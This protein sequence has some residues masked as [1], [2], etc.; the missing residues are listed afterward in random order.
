MTE[1]LPPSDAPVSPGTGFRFDGGTVVW[2]QTT[3]ATT[4]QNGIFDDNDDWLATYSFS[5]QVVV[6]VGAGGGALVRRMKLAENNSPI[7]RDRIFGFYNYF[8]NVPGGFGDVHRFTPGFEKTFVDGI[9]SLDVRLPFAS[10]LSSNQ[11]AGVAES[12]GAE[13][14]NVTATWKAILIQRQ[15]VLVSGGVGLG[16]PTAD[17]TR[18][19]MP[20]GTPLLHIHNDAL[21]VLPFA[22]FLWTPDDENFVQGFLQFDLDTNGN[23]VYGGPTGSLPSLGRIQD[24]ALMYMDVT[25]GTWLHRNPGGCGITGIAPVIELH[26][27]TTVQ[28]EE[29]LVGEGITVQPLS[30]RFDVLNF[31]MGAHVMFHDRFVITPGVSLPLRGNHDHQFDYEAMVLAN[32]YF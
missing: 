11:I 28:D 22:G 2:T 1:P 10:T 7:P 19:E 30:Q 4:A 32:W 16:F 20:D 15:N 3:A 25:F 27:S 31:T 5:E 13:F 21:H 8:S 23:R 18:V 14:G 9:M 26:Y 24:A 12:A 17:D 6:G 29:S